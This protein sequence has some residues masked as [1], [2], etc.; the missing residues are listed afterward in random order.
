MTRASLGVG[1]TDQRPPLKASQ[2]ALRP[3]TVKQKVIVN[4]GCRDRLMLGHD[5][6]DMGLKCG[7]LAHV[8]MS[9]ESPILRQRFTN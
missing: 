8:L 6:Q 5:E 9:P 3:A 1:R 2:D 7:E 4:L